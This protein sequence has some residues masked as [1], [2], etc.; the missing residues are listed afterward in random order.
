MR[1][2]IGVGTYA[3]FD[4]SIGLRIAEAI[5]ADGLD[6]DFR[7]L[8]LGGN[9]LDLVHY[10]DATVEKVLIVDAAKLGLE[11]GEYR[12]FNAGDVGTR[13]QLAGI[14]THEG[15][16]LKV[17]EFAGS[18]GKHVPPVAFLGIEPAKLHPG[19][20]LSPELERRFAE[21]VEAA[22]RFFED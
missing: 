6:R 11:P 4:D 14:S 22:V 18:L 10:L 2:L 19:V 17:L 1:Y 12:F 5:S 8:E 13:K 20:G 9:V 16:V 21:Y 15:D 3:G 7:A